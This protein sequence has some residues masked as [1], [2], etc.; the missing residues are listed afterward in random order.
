MSE[1]PINKEFRGIDIFA[2]NLFV[3]RI[4]VDKQF[5]NLMSHTRLD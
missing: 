4:F 5:L 3:D 2:S 1:I